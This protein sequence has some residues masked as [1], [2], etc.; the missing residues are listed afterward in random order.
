MRRVILLAALI[1][2]SCQAVSSL[3]SPAITIAPP[4]ATVLPT[5]IPST[6]TSIPE[7]T[8]TAT[9]E[10]EF[11]V[12]LHP[13][14]SLFVG[15][16]ISMEVISRGD[17]VLE[18]KHVQIQVIGVKDDQATAEFSAHGIGERMQATFNWIW[19]T[20]SLQPGDYEVNFSIQPEGPAWKETVRLQSQTSVPDPEPAAHWERVKIE[21]CEI[22]YIS[23]TDFEQDLATNLEIIKSQAEEAAR[24]MELDFEERIT[25]T[26]LSR[27]LG[28]GGFASNE[29]YVS[30]LEDNY[31]GNDLA[32]VLH[33]EMVHILDHRLGGELRP[34]LFVEGLAVYLSEG[35]FKKEP[36]VSRAAALVDLGWYLPLA[37][38]AD[39]FYTSQHEIGYLEGGALVNFMVNKYGWGAFSDFY[40]DIHPHPSDLQSRA[41]DKALKEHFG[42]SFEQLEGL[43]TADLQRKHINPDM[44]ADLILSVNFYEAVRGYQ[45]MLDRSAYF[46][47]AW[48]PAGEEMRERG[49]VAD[50]LRR[51]QDPQNLE[52]VEL[53][54]EIDRQIRAG[55]YL[56]AEK[57]LDLVNRKLDL[58]QNED[59]AGN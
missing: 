54:V 53:L 17:L 42:I 7:A 44:R 52:L 34:S 43:F 2:V 39:S 28:H 10:A 49:I 58:I 30:H 59:L 5:E 51:P 11:E 15:D 9:P 21:C 18:D 20:S 40:R 22:H 46:L 1:I 41:I 50:Y 57:A 35:H 4:S 26:I 25:I 56:E 47:T 38:L 55:N 12:L 37:D 33:H 27:V 19:D 48:L 13:D 31:A 45:L 3:E 36:L 24:S 29:I 23:G 14:G 6:A 16:Q 8:A 32:Q